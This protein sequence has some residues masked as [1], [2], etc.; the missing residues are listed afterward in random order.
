VIAC[1]EMALIT[2]KVIML[3][4]FATNIGET[5]MYLLTLSLHLCTDTR[6]DL[7]SAQLLLI[8]VN[9]IF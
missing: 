2:T 7:F 9:K 3:M 8:F 6:S 5:L 1:K 4:L